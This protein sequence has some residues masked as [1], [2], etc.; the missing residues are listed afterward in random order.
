VFIPKINKASQLRR[1][2]MAIGDT[3]TKLCK[4]A[5]ANIQLAFEELGGLT[6][7]VEWANNTPQNLTSFYTQIWPR[8]VPKDIKS[9]I[10]GAEGKE[11]VIKIVQFGSEDLEE[12]QDGTFP[13]QESLPFT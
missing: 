6:R 3:P 8:I 5:K 2:F 13:A 7:L 11:L 4:D 12:E 9:E 1:K 10:T